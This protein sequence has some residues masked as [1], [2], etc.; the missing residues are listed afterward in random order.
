MGTK[1]SAAGAPR[2]LPHAGEHHHRGDLP[3]EPGPTVLV[4]RQRSGRVRRRHPELVQLRRLPRLRR[5]ARSV[6]AGFDYIAEP[7]PYSSP[8]QELVLRRHRHRG[9]PKDVYL[10]LLQE[11]V[12]GGSRS[13]TSCRTWNWTA[14]T[15]VTVYV[16]NNCDSV[17]SLPEQHL[18]GRKDDVGR[19]A[20]LEWSV[21]WAS[22]TLRRLHRRQRGRQR[23]GRDGRRRVVLS[24]DRSS[25]TADG[26]DL[27][28]ITG[29]LQDANS[30]FAPHRL[31]LRRLPGLQ[32]AVGLDS[33]PPTPRRT[34]GRAARRSAS[35]VSAVVRIFAQRSQ[36][37]DRGALQLSPLVQ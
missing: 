14:G 17:G 37:R 5:P 13:S 34:R 19:R 26:R 4:L 25:I 35:R 28:F 18:A 15:T 29:D 32:A 22:R 20:R 6:W 11:P 30:L 21:P 27:A 3:V 16:Y 23:P 24:A 36:R 12:D 33:D 9:F 1:T 8:P 10:L 7:T 31:Q 2:H